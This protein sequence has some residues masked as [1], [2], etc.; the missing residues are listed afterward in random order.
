MSVTK[1]TQELKSIILK[2]VENR[3]NFY[4]PYAKC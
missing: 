2:A 1:T 3:V 4:F